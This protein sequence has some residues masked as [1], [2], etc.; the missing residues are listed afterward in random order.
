MG[1]P[2]AIVRDPNPGVMRALLHLVYDSVWLVSAVVAVPWWGWRCWR[3]LGF[4]RLAWERVFGARG[5][6]ARGDRRARILVHGVS[7]G[8]VKGAQSLIQGLEREYP[9]HEVVI[10]ATTDTG[11]AVAREV[12]PGR[13][14]LRF[15]LDFSPLVHG[16]M[17]RVRPEM[18]VL[19]ELEIWPNF[20]RVCN[21]RGIPV[22]VVNGRITER[23]FDRY[24]VF[25]SWLPQFNRI[26]VFCAQL[27]QYAERFGDLCSNL[28]R[29][30]VTGNIKADGMPT[31]AVDPGEDLRRWTPEGCAPVVLV[32]GSTHGQ[33]EQWFLEAA[34]RAV[35]EGRVILVPR[36]PRRTPEIL[37]GLGALGCRPQ[38]LSELR[39]GV[40]SLDTGRPLLVDTIGELERIYGLADLVYVGGSLVPH[41]GQNM[42]EPSAQGRPVVYGPHTENFTNETALLELAGASV[43]VADTEE[44]ASVLGRLGSDPGERER[45]GRAGLAAV[46]GQKGATEATL[47]AL[48]TRCRPN[49]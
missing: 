6:R 14:V 44:L 41:G 35:P 19:V 22:A 24:R 34:R 42:L 16:F 7:V 37:E 49:P 27:E 4:R 32:A 1:V 21:R 10:S 25:R 43:R 29:V 36:H 23:S 28:D 9:E 5:F 45:M 30:V 2:G 31:G 47:G 18:V 38:L 39:A 48:G 15:P 33:E 20:L 12:Y 11:L 8:E 40:E 3:D 13:S 26:T 17:G 46:E